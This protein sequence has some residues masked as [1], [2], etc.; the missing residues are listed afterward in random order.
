MNAPPGP[1]RVGPEAPDDSPAVETRKT[2]IKAAVLLGVVVLGAVLYRLT[3][4][5]TWLQPA[6]EL[7]AWVRQTGAWGVLA[8][9]GISTGLI[10]AG[11]PR[12]LFCPIAGALYGFWGGL[13]LCLLAATISY[14]TTFTI[15]RGRRTPRARTRLPRGLAFLGR[16]PGFWGV[17]LARLIPLPGMVVTL[18]LSLSGVS[19]TSY[20]LG[21]VVGMIPEAAPLVL[22]GC[23]LLHPGPEN[24]MHFAAIGVLL[25]ASFWF[26]LRG[27]RQRQRDTGG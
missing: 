6:G 8:F 12:L 20:L 10:F 7:G 1:D 25:V 16:D 9:L 19:R 4:L 18:A 11:L 2:L 21:S 13:G 15:V 23:G 22:L 26:A 17:V 14:F 5:R 24:Y 3:P 27:F